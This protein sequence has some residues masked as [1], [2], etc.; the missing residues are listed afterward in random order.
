[1]QRFPRILD[2][3]ASAAGLFLLSPVLLVIS[4]LVRSS[5]PGPILYRA[6]RVGQGGVEFTLLKFRSMKQDAAAVG[7]A[8]TSANDSRIT[9]IGRFLRATKI[10]E[11]PQLVNVLRGEM[12][13]VGPRPEDPR[14]I[15]YYP[16]EFRRILDL[17]PGI[18]S[19]ASLTFVDESSLLRGEDH[20]RVYIEEVLPEKLRIDLEWFDRARVVDNIGLIVRTVLRKGVKA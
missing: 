2:L 1:M 8:I 12:C 4:A 13:L 16:D 18:T 19:A 5:S 15:Q 6:R 3:A 11:L 7:S 14:Y 17:K 20:E 9:G 10:D